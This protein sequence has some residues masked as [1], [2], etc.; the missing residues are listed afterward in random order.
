VTEGGFAHVVADGERISLVELAGETLAVRGDSAATARVVDLVAAGDAPADGL[1]IRVRDEEE[2]A[3]ALEELDPELL[4][5]AGTLDAVLEL[6]E[7]VPAGKLAIAE[8]ASPTDDDVAE[9]ERAGMDAVIVT[10]PP[11]T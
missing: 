1:A 3:T 10:A 9:L 11:L 6:L 2:L 4:V 5:L 7:D 8:L